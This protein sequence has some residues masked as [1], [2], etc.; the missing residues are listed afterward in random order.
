MVKADDSL[1]KGPGFDSCHCILN[2][3]HDFS[4]NETCLTLKGVQRMMMVI[5]KLTVSLGTESPKFF[6]TIITLLYDND[7]NNNVT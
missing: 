5:K 4:P 2:G 6:F 3:S 7:E 1:S